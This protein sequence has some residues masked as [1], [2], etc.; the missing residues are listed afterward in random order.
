MQLAGMAFGMAAKSLTVG[1]QDAHLHPCSL[2]LSA[3]QQALIWTMSNTSIQFTTRWL[4]HP[5][6]K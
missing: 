5:Y 4:G 6:V 1:P 2:L 3:L